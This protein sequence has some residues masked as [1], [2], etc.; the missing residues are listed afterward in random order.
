MG[1]W[2]LFLCLCPHRQL[3]WRP[4]KQGEARKRH[5]KVVIIRNMFH[6]SDF[7]VQ[8]RPHMNTFTH[9]CRPVWV[10]MSVVFVGRPT[11]AE[12]VSW[13]STDRVWEV[14]RG[15]ESHPLWCELNVFG[16]YQNGW[17]LMLEA[18]IKCDCIGAAETPRRCGISCVQGAW[19]SWCVHSVV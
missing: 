19:A 11:G 2:L 16:T 17:N 1:S 5:E 18:S 9:T 6:P 8:R 4:E 15:Q 12:W 14:W 7:E 10:L 13:R 3:D